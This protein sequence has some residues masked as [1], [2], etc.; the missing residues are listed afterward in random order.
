MAQRKNR[1]A[2]FEAILMIQI[3]DPA[4]K[5]QGQPDSG[6]ADWVESNQND[7]LDRW[8][9]E[10]FDDCEENVATLPLL[11]L[12]AY[13][14]WDMEVKER[15]MKKPNVFNWEHLNQEVCDNLIYCWWE[16]Q[17]E[18]PEEFETQCWEAHF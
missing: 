12:L 1:R 4:W 15:G 6:E 5:T 18:A 11:E 8:L 7:I 3:Q 10:M 17:D 9:E 2:Q 16:Q 13:G 14:V